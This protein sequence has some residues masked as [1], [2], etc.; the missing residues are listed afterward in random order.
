MGR[1][2]KARA[3]AARAR[4]EGIPS[5]SERLGGG[6]ADPPGEL[7]VLDH[8]GHPL[9]VDRAEVGVLEEVDE[10]VAMAVASMVASLV[11]T[12]VVIYS[13]SP[14]TRVIV[15]HGT[16]MMRL[17]PSPSLSSSPSLNLCFAS[18]SSSD[19]TY[20]YTS[21][22]TRYEIWTFFY[23]MVL[24]GAVALFEAGSVLQFTVGIFMSVI[25]LDV[26]LRCVLLTCP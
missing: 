13:S 23:R 9:R 25:I 1:A 2:W 8:D 7:D 12:L 6:A 17:R 19:F 21:P 3:A 16:R 26:Q 4:A 11:A 24:T 5:S 10:V 14:G 22:Y 18:A 15:I 20:T